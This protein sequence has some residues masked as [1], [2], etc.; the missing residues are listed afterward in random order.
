MADNSRVESGGGQAEARSLERHTGSDALVKFKID[1]PASG[2]ETKIYEI[3]V[4]SVD[5]TRDY[6]FDEVQ[7][8]GSLEPTLATTEIRYNGSFEW[9]GQNPFAM[10]KL[11]Q[12]PSTADNA[13]HIDANR[14]IRF[15]LTV[16][17]YNHERLNDDDEEKTEHT[18]VFKRC[19]ITSAD[20]DLSTG[21]V[22]SMTI[23]WEAETA[24]WYLGPPQN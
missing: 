13:R 11:L 19:M 8:N 18:V 12:G 24:D 5:W 7:H 2:D 14:P 17:E 10:D 1:D 21:E 3:P 16:E 4:T 22:S 23:D 9:Q 15:K 20:R 6:S